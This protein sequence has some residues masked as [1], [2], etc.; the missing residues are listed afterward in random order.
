AADPGDPQRLIDLAAAWDRLGELGLAADK[1]AAAQD[2]FA[3]AV[4]CVR[5]L[6]AEMGERML[7]ALLLKL[8]DAQSAAG[9]HHSARAAL[10]ESFHLRL[11]FS[12]RVKHERGALRDLAV[13]LEHLGI[14]AKAAR[15]FENARAAWEEELL[16]AER[17]F[18]V[19]DH[20]ALRFRARVHAHLA[21]LPI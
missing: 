19:L 3:R 13:A 8:G 6:P 2:P 17:I 15:D 12:E 14:A 21:A 16:L 9:N 1:P 5:R 7:A 10:R 4:E 18:P 20:D 11:V